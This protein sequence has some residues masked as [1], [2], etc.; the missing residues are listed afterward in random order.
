MT[1]YTVSV[2]DTTTSATTLQEVQAVVMEAATSLLARDPEGAADG[3]MMAHR[4]FSAGTVRH[5]LDTGGSWHMSLTVHGEP[6]PVVVVKNSE[7]IP[8]PSR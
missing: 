5:A 6:V 4:A 1:S 7:V 2:G 8:P 3:A